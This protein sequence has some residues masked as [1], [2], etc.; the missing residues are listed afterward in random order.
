MIA[1][2]TKKRVFFLGVVWICIFILTVLL[3]AGLGFLGYSSKLPSRCV[4]PP[5]FKQTRRSIYEF[6][7][8][9]EYNSQGIR[10][11]EIPLGK[12]SAD[13]V[14]FFLVGDSF[15]EGSG[16]EADETF[17]ANLERSFSQ[18]GQNVR[19]INGGIRG[20]EP[21][22]QLRTLYTVGFHYDIDSVLICL[23]VNDLMGCPFDSAYTPESSWPPTP[24]GLAKILYKIYPRFFVIV[25]NL[26]HYYT[27]NRI[28][29]G[30]SC[31]V[32]AEV[33]YQA[34]KQGVSEEAITKWKDSLPADL[35]AAANRFEL[36]RS[37]LSLSLLSPDYL[38]EC[39]NITKPSS[40]ILFKNM[41]MILNKMVQECRDRSISV[42]AILIPSVYMCDPNSVS[43]ASSR[44]IPRPLV[45]E[46]WLTETTPLQ[47]GLQKWAEEAKVPFLD[48]TDTF[49][50]AV[51]KYPTPLYYPLDTHWTPLGHQV[52]GEAI[53][54]WLDENQA[55]TKK[56]VLIK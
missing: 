21:L 46:S 48:L 1:S 42:Y 7:C 16:V 10:Y 47:S 25:M 11:P 55:I 12:E 45:S 13:E 51:K 15:T 17:G 52:A 27:N 19:F 54:R 4:Y 53:R 3:D 24:D 34:R 36:N 33:S 23:Y 9:F 50:E 40:V 29:R 41:Q 37:L 39:I 18:S 14:R 22:N 6:E 8:Q 56:N 31:D 35:L 38:L 32:V 43:P 49:R 5:G 26:Q 44:N 20:T 2:K 30:D 28:Q